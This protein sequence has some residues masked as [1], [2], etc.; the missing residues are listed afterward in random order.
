MKAK[1]LTSKKSISLYKCTK[2]A[3][4]TKHMLLTLAF[5]PS[6]SHATVLETLKTLANNGDMKA[7]YEL[8]KAYEGGL[9]G[10]N[11]SYFKAKNWYEKA[12]EQG[13]SD[14][15]NKLGLLYNDGNGVRQDFLIARRMYEK[16]AKLGHAEAQGNIGILH[17]K[18]EG[19]P[20]NIN[21]ARNMFHYAARMGDA[22]SYYYL[23]RMQLDYSPQTPHGLKQ[24]KEYFG[25]ACDGG[26]QNGCVWF[27]KLNEAL[28]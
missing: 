10:A 23:G 28:R 22:N 9:L 14:A 11:Q 2:A 25:K 18:G 1:K 20:V 21:Y 8:A 17:L 19:L 24:A 27:R 4:I 7:Q 5:I 3:L 12:A 15:Y 16:A 6:Q 26:V 13:S